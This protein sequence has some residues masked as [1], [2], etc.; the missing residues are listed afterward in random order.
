MIRQVAVCLDFMHRIDGTHTVALE[1]DRLDT[2]CVCTICSC[3]DQ[4]QSQAIQ[5]THSQAAR[6][7]GSKR[8]SPT[9]QARQADHHPPHTASEANQA[10]QQPPT[11]TN[12]SPRPCNQASRERDWTGARPVG[13]LPPCLPARCCVAVSTDLD[14]QLMGN[15]DRRGGREISSAW[16]PPLTL[17]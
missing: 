10:K 14:S 1:F 4:L 11:K 6:Q 7:A 2:S 3:I 5:H 13:R 8:D 17:S 12:G 16:P 15:A 9:A